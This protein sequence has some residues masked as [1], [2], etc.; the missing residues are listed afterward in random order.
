MAGKA[1]A[2]WKCPKCGRRFAHANQAHS[3]QVVPM[4]P[5]RAKAPPGV[6][7]IY[8]AVMRALRA[9]G[10]VQ[11]APTKTSINLLSRTSLGGISLHKSYLNLGLV[12]SHRVDDRRVASVLQISPR[13]FAHR[14]RLQSVADVDAAVRRWLRE[15]YQ[16]GLMAGHRPS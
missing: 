7:R 16:V 8:Q 5:H 4:S 6:R 10:P 15:A 3:C 9:C 2:M 12:L 14:L 13:S 1:K 11:V